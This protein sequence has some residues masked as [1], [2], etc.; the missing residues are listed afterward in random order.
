MKRSLSF[1][2]G[3]TLARQSELSNRIPEIT[4]HCVGKTRG[5][6]AEASNRLVVGSLQVIGEWQTGWVCFDIVTCRNCTQ[7]YG[8]GVVVY[9]S[10]KKDD[11]WNEERYLSTCDIK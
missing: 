2:S 7:H 5:I 1:I 11:V 9:Y 8:C 6:R 4:Y 10:N 3:T